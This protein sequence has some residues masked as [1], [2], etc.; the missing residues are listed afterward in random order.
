MGKK[1]LF[2]LELKLFFIY[3]VHFS[4]TIDWM[5]DFKDLMFFE[6][7]GEGTEILD[8]LEVSLFISGCINIGMFCS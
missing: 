4:N 2:F 6:T 3:S 8:S 5:N 7:S 1:R